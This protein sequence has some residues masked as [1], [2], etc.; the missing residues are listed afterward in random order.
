[1]NQPHKPL[2]QYFNKLNHNLYWILPVV[3]NIKK[4]Y[5]NAEPNEENS[6]IINIE[7]ERD[8]MNINDIVNNY[9]SNTLPSE[10]NKNSYLY[11]ELNPYFT[12]FDLI[13]DENNNGIIIEKEC[14]K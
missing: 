12:P 11:T 7:F 10:Q 9:K 3:K 5:H 13:N 8:I 4:V 14:R 6:D 1:M 2:S